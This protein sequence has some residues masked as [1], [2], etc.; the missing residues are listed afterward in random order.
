MIKQFNSIDDYVKFKKYKEFDSKLNEL[1]KS[2][3]EIF[4]SKGHTKDIEETDKLLNLLLI[5]L[6]EFK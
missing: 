2:W 4:E 5:K 1:K 6:D 3:D